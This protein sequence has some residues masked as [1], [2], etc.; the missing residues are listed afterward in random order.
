MSAHAYSEVQFVEQTFIRVLT[1][2]DWK[3]TSVAMVWAESVT[4]GVRFE[5]HHRQGVRIH[6]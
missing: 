5:R 1:A 4:S 6:A 3:M 2:L